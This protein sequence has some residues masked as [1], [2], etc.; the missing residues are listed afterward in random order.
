MNGPLISVV[1]PAYNADQYLP[2]SIDSVLAQGYR[3]LEVIVV[4]DGPTYRCSEIC[5]TYPGVIYVAQEHAGPA[6]AMN[7]G[8]AQ[9]R[10]D[11]VAFH[12]ADDIMLAGKLEAQMR[13]FLDAPNLGMVLTDLKNFIQPGMATPTWFLDE[14]KL[15][16]RMGFVNTA[17]VRR[18]ILDMVGEF[19]SSY[20]IGQDIDWLIRAREIGVES[21]LL[22]ETYTRRRIHQGNLSADVAL[23]RANLL[24]MI[25]AS[26][27]RKSAAETTTN[28]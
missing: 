18:Q 25:Q 27:A 15:R 14:A 19:D 20:L 1:I 16:N 2:A 7:K 21:L 26:I 10:G 3:N 13:A 11:Y 28:A 6:T 17:L 22:N 8:T 4:D 5:K 12:D 9:T 24:K 23:G